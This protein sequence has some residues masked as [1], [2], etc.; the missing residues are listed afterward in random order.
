M[1]IVK[2]IEVAALA[3]L[4]A[5]LGG[6]AACNQPVTGPANVYASDKADLGVSDP[7]AVG[8]DNRVN[9]DSLDSSSGYSDRTNVQQRP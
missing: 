2:T 5:A 1:R 7:N 4:F 3:G 6:L 8:A 9:P